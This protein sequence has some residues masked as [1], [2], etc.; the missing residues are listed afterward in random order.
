MS[1]GR[2]G[3]GLA[4]AGIGH[5]A[6][7]LAGLTWA[8]PPASTLVITSYSIHYTKLYESNRE[9]HPARIQMGPGVSPAEARE[10]LARSLSRPGIRDL[11]AVRNGRAY[12]IWHHF[13]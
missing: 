3:L 7:L 6:V 5:G 9:S 13:V 11:D 10:S 1:E 2:W 12:A 8:A 4:L